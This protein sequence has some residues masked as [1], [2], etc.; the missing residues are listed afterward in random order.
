MSTL[1]HYFVDTKKRKKKG[2]KEVNNKYDHCSPNSLPLHACCL[3]Y[4]HLS[5][6]MSQGAW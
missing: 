5:T 4:L 2:S 6:L 3:D 1:A